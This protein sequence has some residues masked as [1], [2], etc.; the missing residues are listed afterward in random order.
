VAKD[1]LVWVLN[2][3][4]LETLLIKKR[5]NTERFIDRMGALS[6]VDSSEKGQQ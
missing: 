1:A 6:R 5:T 2:E 4:S 3:I